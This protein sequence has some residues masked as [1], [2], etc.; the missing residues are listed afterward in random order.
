[1][2]EFGWLN[3]LHSHGTSPQRERKA[4]F[5]LNPPA[6][7]N[8]PGSLTVSPLYSIMVLN[9]VLVSSCIPSFE[10]HPRASTRAIDAAETLQP[11]TPHD[12][13]L[14]TIPSAT[15]PAQMLQLY[16]D[17]STSGLSA[18]ANQNTTKRYSFRDRPFSNRRRLGCPINNSGPVLHDLP[19]GSCIQR[20]Y[21]DCTPLN[22]TG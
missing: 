1:V 6:T 10:P 20:R 4:Q 17:L 15:W 5:Q 7:N 2:G 18:K 9:P 12:Q 8:W 14:D 19:A 22:T 16:S 13:H 21:T 11:N 3:I